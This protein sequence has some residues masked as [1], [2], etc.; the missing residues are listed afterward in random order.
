MEGVDVGRYTRIKRAIIDKEVKLLRNNNRYDLA[1]D[2][3]RFHVTD[4]GIVV[5]GKGTG[6]KIAYSLWLIAKTIN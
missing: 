4:S 2:K 5:V 6:D 3:K 1:E